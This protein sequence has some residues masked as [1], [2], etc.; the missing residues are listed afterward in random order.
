LLH[1]LAEFRP[2]VVYHLAAISIPADCGENE[3]NDLAACVN[4][5]GTERL[6]RWALAQSSPPRVVFISSSAVYAPVAADNPPIGE[7]WPLAPRRG[8][9]KSKL[10]AEQLVREAA[11][12]RGLPIVVARAFQHTGPGQSLRMIVPDLASQFARGD[13]PIRVLSLDTF[14]DLTDVRDVVRAYRE[15][16]LRGQSGETYNVGGGARRSGHEI[17]AMLERAAGARRAVTEIEPG[18][19]WRPIAD[20]SK[21]SRVTAWKPEI[22]L[23]TT[24]ADTL[25]FWKKW[26]FGSAP[27]GVKTD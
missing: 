1:R 11:E 24:I 25:A 22:P 8:Y 15:L 9:G 4:V 10:A 26:P 19:R 3:P 20:I 12:R 21:L 23:E 18:L 6:V 5:G 16:A 13:E 2:E 17:V 27:E 14:L 7:D